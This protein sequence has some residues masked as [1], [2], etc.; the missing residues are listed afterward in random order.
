MINIYKTTWSISFKTSLFLFDH[1]SK[2][3]LLSSSIFGKWLKPYK[4]CIYMQV[5]CLSD[6]CRLEGGLKYKFHNYVVKKGELR[7]S[8]CRK[9]EAVKSIYILE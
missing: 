3:K 9:L 4:T 2:V 5:S 1:S 8:S 7:I 6:D